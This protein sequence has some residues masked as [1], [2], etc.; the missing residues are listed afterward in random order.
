M[1]ATCDLIRKSL[2]FV[3]LHSIGMRGSFYFENKLNALLGFDAHA[4]VGVS[5]TCAAFVLLTLFSFFL[6]FPYHSFLC[7]LVNEDR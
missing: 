7:R 3:S 5:L 4:A 1:L 6:F 2:F